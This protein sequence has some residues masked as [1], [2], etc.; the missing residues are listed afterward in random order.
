MTMWLIEPRDPLIVR[1]GRPFGPDPGA[2]AASLSFPFPST[3]AGGVRTRAGLDQQGV[4]D[5]TQIDAVQ[6]IAVRGPLLVTL[7]RNGGIAQWFFPAPA[8]ALVLRPDKNNDPLTVKPLSP[9]N[10]PDDA[11]TDLPNDLAPVGLPKPDPHKPADNAPRFWQGERFMDWLYTPKEQ[12][13]VPS[14]LGIGGPV[15]E[16]R[17]HVRLDP[18]TL[19]GADGA[20]F[21][22]RGLEWTY[23]T[24]DAA[25]RPLLD[26]AQRLALV[27]VTDAETI[28]AGMAP[29][30]GERRM[31]RWMPG[32][33]TL[34][35]CPENVREQIKAT[36][37]CRLILV[38]PAHFE[39]GHRPQWLLEPHAGI[40][41]QLVAAAVG[42]P[43]VV[44]G[45]DVAADNGA[46]KP[47]GKPKP[48][49]RLGPAGSVYFLKLD[50]DADAIDAW[51][52]TMWM[53]CLSDDEQSRLDGF[54]LAVVGTWS[55]EHQPLHIG[56]TT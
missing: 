7:D 33:T 43:Q 50:G 31:V 1:D 19:T 25:Q 52:D 36:R 38:T 37:A 56:A 44:S 53:Q 34:P 27:V 9:L 3:L 30:G 21:Q 8:D 29:L 39:N 15:Q 46:N 17:M 55:G 16:G 24:T 11:T 22:T 12:L 6:W 49:R 28:V 40:T 35:A 20:L 23:T 45:W 10:L 42:R 13:L 47:K 26:T 2:R 5:E 4:F 54:G 14:D 32:D 48:T 51:I 41:A 18:Q